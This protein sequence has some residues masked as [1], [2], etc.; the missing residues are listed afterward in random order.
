MITIDCKELTT[1]EELALA[2][3]VSDSLQGAAVALIQSGGIVLDDY[4]PGGLK[5]GDVQRL[6]EDFF[7]AKDGGYEVE[8]EGS[9]IL[10]HSSHPDAGLKRGQP[11]LPPNL[12]K[13]PFCPF[14]TPYQEMYVV[15]TRAH[16]FGV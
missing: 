2:S 9:R 6:V 12:L 3:S 7:A 15:H 11:T 13:C 10:V 14:V 16:L 1:D 4:T 5:V 8:A